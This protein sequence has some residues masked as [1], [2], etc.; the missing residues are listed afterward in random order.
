[1]ILFD[2]NWNPSYDHQAMC[3]SYRY[4]QTKPVHV[5]RLVASGTMEEYVYRRQVIKETIAM[6][7]VDDRSA[8]RQQGAGTVQDI[9]FN[10]KK[11]KARQQQ[12]RKNTYKR[13]D[14]GDDAVLKSVVNNRNGWLIEWYQQ[15]TLFTV[16]DS[17]ISEEV[18]ERALRNY[19]ESSKG[20]DLHS[21][22]TLQSEP[23]WMTAPRSQLNREQLLRRDQHDVE[24]QEKLK[25]ARRR[26]AG[27]GQ[28]EPTK[29]KGNL[30]Q[31]TGS[32]RAEKLLSIGD[33]WL[34]DTEQKEKQRILKERGNTLNWLKERLYF[35][36][37]NKFNRY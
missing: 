19:Q 20:V 7:V 25:E 13:E 17:S 24:Y 28:T 6:H 2:V 32:A 33:P 4:G 37:H 30:S 18:G 36:P 10:L 3:R 8:Q 9:F 12:A 5:Y 34:T 21:S 26:N 35:V 15:D 11:L 16:E 22:G 31:L 1:M 29:A 27:F 14:V 23:F